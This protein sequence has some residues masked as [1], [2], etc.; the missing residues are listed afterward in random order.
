MAKSEPLKIAVFPTSIFDE[1]LYKA[2]SAIIHAMVPNVRKLERHLAVFCQACEADE[3]VLFERATLLV[4]AT[5]QK[6]QHGD[7]T[8]YEKISTMIK[9]FKHSCSYLVTV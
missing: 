5:A 3:V 8:K 6:R 4:I 2:W 7:V 1:S 9:N